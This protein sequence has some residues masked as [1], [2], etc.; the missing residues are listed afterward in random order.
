MH[1]LTLLAVTVALAATACTDGRTPRAAPSRTPYP[2]PAGRDRGCEHPKRV[3][4][5]AGPKAWTLTLPG[6]W[7]RVT[8]IDTR[9]ATTVLSAVSG[10]YLP[11]GGDPEVAA[12]LAKEPR[13]VVIDGYTAKGAADALRAGARVY[14][15]RNQHDRYDTG[16]WLRGRAYGVLGD[17]AKERTAAVAALLGRHA[18]DYLAAFPG[19]PA[20][21][22]RRMLGYLPSADLEREAFRWRTVGPG[23]TPPAVL[24]RLRRTQLVVDVPASWRGDAVVCGTFGLGG[25]GCADLRDPRPV[26]LYYDPT[27][28]MTFVLRRGLADPQLGRPLGVVDLR[29]GGPRLTLTVTAERSLRETLAEP[30]R[31]NGGAR[32][33][34][35]LGQV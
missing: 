25:S 28:P 33:T 2:T 19:K 8:N 21:E 27:M 13:Q 5:L 6:A 3:H 32:I 9:H 1:R 29:E 26:T 11:L 15:H 17:C 24:A 34:A 10:T 23:Y 22:V 20:A 12:R 18:P 30:D 4:D 16:Y 35:R 14:L 31:G 7:V